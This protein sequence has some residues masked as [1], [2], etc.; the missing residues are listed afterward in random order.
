MLIMQ[1][2]LII[3]YLATMSFWWAFDD[4]NSFNLLIKESFS[5]VFHNL[6][7]NETVKLFPLEL[8]E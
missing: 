7:L 8:L 4:S 1:L 3:Y 2:F 5:I 6:I